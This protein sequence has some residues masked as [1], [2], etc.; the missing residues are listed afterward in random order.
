MYYF[1]LNPFFEKLKLQNENIIVFLKIISNPVN[2][3]DTISKKTRHHVV[4]ES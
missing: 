2:V 1:M 4:S 3:I